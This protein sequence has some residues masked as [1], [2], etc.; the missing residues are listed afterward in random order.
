MTKNEKESSVS[1]EIDRLVD[2]EQESLKKVFA[3]KHQQLIATTEVFK[4]SLHS[5]K[6]QGW[7]THVQLWNLGIYLNIAAH[8]LSVMVEQLTFERELWA[9]KLMARHTAVLIYET[10]EDMRSLLGKN[11][12]EPLAI[13]GLLSRFDSE[14]RSVREPLDRFWDKYSGD[15]KRIRCTSAAH[16]DHDGLTLLEVVESV[17]F[18]AIRGLGLEL[19]HILNDI[20]SIIQSI[21]IESANVRPPELRSDQD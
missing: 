5:S 10:V 11:L 7:H 19:G 12:R 3:A 2:Q 16:R 15:L 14:I 21:L 18:Q 9:R 4:Q 20:G 13:L 17:D 1:L 8:D 6:R